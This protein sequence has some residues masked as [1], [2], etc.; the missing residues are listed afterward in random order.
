MITLPINNDL[1]R[2][3]RQTNLAEYLLRRGEPLKKDGRGRYKHAE[4]DSLVFTQNAFYWNSQGD[5]HG[6]AIDFLMMFYKMDFKTALNELTGSNLSIKK[7]LAPA[8]KLKQVPVSTNISSTFSLPQLADNM[9]R[10]FAYL[11]KTRKIDSEIVQHLTK[12]K[13]LFQDQRGNI[14]FPWL[15][16]KQE[17]VGAELNGTLTDK[18]FKGIVTDSQYGYGFSVK[19]SLFQMHNNIYF[20]ESAIDL[21][22]FWTLHKGETRGMMLV[23]MAGLKKEVIEGYLRRS[24]R[25]LNVH[26]CVDTDDAGKAFAEAV[27]A[28]IKAE[29]I[30]VPKGKDWNEYLQIQKNQGNI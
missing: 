30:P 7:E 18:R 17:I 11:I 5:L 6:N 28:Q 15:N 2:Q 21:L 3:A 4:Y 13:K 1:I 10:T 26:L 8:T 24:E 19:F 22:S 20:F 16:E 25:P 12:N 9:R 29:Y 23:S 27:Q 14:V